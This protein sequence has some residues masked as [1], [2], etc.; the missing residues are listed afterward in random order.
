MRAGEQRLLRRLHDAA[1][2]LAAID[3]SVTVLDAAHTTAVLI[4]TCNPDQPQHPRPGRRPC[5]AAEA[6]ATSAATTDDADPLITDRGRGRT[7]NDHAGHDR[8]DG[9]RAIRHGRPR[10]G[11]RRARRPH[12]ATTSTTSRRRA[13]TTLDDAFDGDEFDDEVD[14]DFDD[15]VGRGARDLRAEAGLDEAGSDVASWTTKPS[16][17]AGRGPAGR[18][19]R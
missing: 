8:H 18:W 16:P 3:V 5:R 10:S 14:D 7:R 9:Y 15:E 17:V 12:P 4:A 11:P 6:P 19:T 1:T 13:P 2:L